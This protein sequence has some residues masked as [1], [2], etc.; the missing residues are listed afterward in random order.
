MVL[1]FDFWTI[2][3]HCFCTCLIAMAWPWGM[4]C[5]F[6]LYFAVCG[7]QQNS[8]TTQTRGKWRSNIVSVPKASVV[9]Q[10]LA[11]ANTELRNTEWF[12]PADGTSWTP[13]K[14]CMQF[15]FC[16]TNF[17]LSPYTEKLSVYFLQIICSTLQLINC[18]VK[19]NPG[20]LENAS[21]VGLVRLPEQFMIPKFCW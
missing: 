11:R 17:W 19:D 7:I 18:I 10:S 13:H 14:P 4:F 6:V 15:Y 12:P 5:T 3:T 9:L 1:V 16:F 21:L 2:I 8:S 20:F